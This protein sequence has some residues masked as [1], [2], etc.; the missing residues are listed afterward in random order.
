MSYARSTESIVTIHNKFYFDAGF[1]GLLTHNPHPKAAWT[2]FYAIVLK[3]HLQ[4]WRIYDDPMTKYT[5]FLTHGFTGPIIKLTSFHKTTTATTNLPL[6][7]AIAAR[8][9]IYLTV[10][11]SASFIASPAVAGLSHGRPVFAG[12]SFGSCRAQG[13]ANSTSTQAVPRRK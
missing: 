10:L 2:F 4:T 12:T 5:T 6:I 11:M 3:I 7:L 9:V 13:H 1:G 8:S